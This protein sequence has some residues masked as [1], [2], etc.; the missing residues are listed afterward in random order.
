[1]LFHSYVFRRLAKIASNSLSIAH[2]PDVGKIHLA[3]AG[4]IP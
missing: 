4:Q 3:V 1:M 2:L